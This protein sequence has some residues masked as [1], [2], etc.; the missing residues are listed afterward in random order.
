[1][2][3]IDSGTSRSNAKLKPL[4]GA[5]AQDLSVRL[6]AAYSIQSLGY[7]DEREA[8][9]SGR[10]M[11]KKTDI[12]IFQEGRPLCG[13]AVK[14]V[15]QNYAQNSN[16]YFENMLGETANLRAGSIPYFQVF[17]IL[18][19]MPYYR[20]DNT[21]SDW[22]EPTAHNIEKYILLDEDNPDIYLHTPD[23]LLFYPVHLPDPF[24]PIMDKT[25]YL[26][27]YRTWLPMLGMQ[28]SVKFPKSTSRVVLRDWETFAEKVYHTILAQ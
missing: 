25:A 5:I 9:I 3:F 23:K 2:R 11:D 17:V 22:E 13:I 27:F 10:Y 24:E 7:G 14:F 20:K 15:M 26:E 19:K 18:D 1:M 8:T 21:I 4:H 12:T 16:N 6:G 28:K